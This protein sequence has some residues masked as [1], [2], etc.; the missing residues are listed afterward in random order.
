MIQTKSSL[1]G[2]FN[3]RVVIAVALC[4]IGASF[5]WLSFASTPPSGTLTDTS[6][7]LTY[8]AGPF[9]Q[10]NVFGNSIAGECDP[11]PSDPLVPCDIYQL[12][13]SLPAGYVQSNPNQHLFVRID[14]STPAAKFDLYLW[15]A[16]AWNGVTSFPNGSP[17]ASSTGNAT[18]FQQIEIAPDAALNGEFVVQVSTTVPAGQSFTLFRSR[19][20][21]PPRV[22]ARFNR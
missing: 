10:P 21:R 13:V 2:I 11:D 19:L 7:P 20:L 6:G 5:G 22:T 17:L 1:A 18:N 3:I 4:S 14:W 15:D 8:T 12:H 9:F 16:R